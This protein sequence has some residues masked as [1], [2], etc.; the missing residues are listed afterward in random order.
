MKNVKL[1]IPAFTLAVASILSLAA[2]QPTTPPAPDMPQPSTTQPGTSAQPGIPQQTTPG[3]P[4]P[5]QQS[6]SPAV[7]VPHTSDAPEVN[8]SEL[9]P[10]SGE[11]VGKIDTKNA[12]AG[13]EVVVKTTEKATFADGIEIPKGSKIMG[14]VTEVQAHDKSN[15]NSK[16]TL[17]FDKAELKGGQTMPIKSVLQS[18]S[19]SAGSNSTP[20]DPY[21]SGSAPSSPAASP[22]SGAS[23]GGSMGNSG[24][25]TM[26][27][28]GSAPA[29]NPGSTSGSTSA[30]TSA[31]NG[32]PQAGTVI[33]HQG[34]IDIKTTGIPGILIAAN[35]N[36]QPFSNAA[37]ALLGAKQNVH[38]DGG[39]QF[40]LAIADANAKASIN[41]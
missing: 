26:P 13:D 27:Q 14:H 24:A 35:S 29:S 31:P 34:N 5:A 12:K 16:L 37:G 10:V 36:G 25:A 17:Q 40:T 20:G 6:A 3:Q 7:A 8:N 23:G 19:A 9:R 39:T 4:D 22:S 41:P 33:A 1:L 18:I 30:T 2:Q 21:G 38:L 11:L 28:Q 15:E 32:A